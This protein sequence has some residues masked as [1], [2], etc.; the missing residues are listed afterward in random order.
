MKKV[1][2]RRREEREE[3]GQLKNHNR[4]QCFEELGKRERHLFFS[5]FC[6]DVTL[7]GDILIWSK[8]GGYREHGKK[9]PVIMQRLVRTIQIF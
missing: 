1:R 8:R 5:V 6:H 2:S 3:E 7:I 4:K 9:G